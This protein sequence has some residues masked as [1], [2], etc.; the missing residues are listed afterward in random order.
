MGTDEQM[1]EAALAAAKLD[2]RILDEGWTQLHAQELLTLS[3][4]SLH[5]R[6]A[7]L[8]TV[9]EQAPRRALPSDWQRHLL[10]D[11]QTSGGLLVAV[12][13]EAAEATLARIRAAGYPLAA[14]VGR[15]GNSLSAIS[16][17]AALQRASA[18]PAQAEMPPAAVIVS[19]TEQTTT[20]AVATAPAP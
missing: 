10:T 2:S 9:L 11:P 8:V 17:E 1:I 13:P 3:P 5:D 12:A 19:A 20:E 4:P 6:L 18:P 7:A 15:I 14:I 16:K